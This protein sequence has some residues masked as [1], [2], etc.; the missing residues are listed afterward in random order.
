MPE[1]L[2]LFSRQQ[3]WQCEM[4]AKYFYTTIF[5]GNTSFINLSGQE[6]IDNFSKELD[7]ETK[8]ICKI[9]FDWFCYPTHT[10]I[11]VSTSL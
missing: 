4:R 8:N 9:Y 1:S 3:G 6:I 5:N 7:E 10:I 2:R 11:T